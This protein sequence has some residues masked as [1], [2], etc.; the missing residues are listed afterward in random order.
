MG[1]RRSS[2]VR[3]E[4]FLNAAMR[5]ICGVLHFNVSVKKMR[6]LMIE[7]NG[8][9]PLPPL[10][11]TIVSCLQLTTFLVNPTKEKAF[12]SNIGIETKGYKMM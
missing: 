12:T 2:R 6:S 1:R 10:T 9:M 4:D 8:V 7:M 11:I 3:S 5:R